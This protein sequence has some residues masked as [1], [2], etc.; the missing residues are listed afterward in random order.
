MIQ[1]PYSVILQNKKN[2]FPARQ[3][4]LS[5][6]VASWHCLLLQNG[7][8]HLKHAIVQIAFHLRLTCYKMS[9]IFTILLLGATDYKTGDTYDPF[10]QPHSSANNSNNIISLSRFLCL[11][12][13]FQSGEG[14]V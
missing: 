4:T 2:Q 7:A 8:C 9:I 1:F 14:L 6:F 12:V 5:I 3:K 10:G 13:L 11:Y